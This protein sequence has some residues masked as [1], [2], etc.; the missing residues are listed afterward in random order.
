MKETKAPKGY[1]TD[2]QVYTAD[3]SGANRESSPVKLSVSDNPAN[4]PIAMLL[5]KYDGQKTYNGAGNLP[6]GSATLAGAEFTVDYYATLDYKSYDDLKK[7]DI[8]STRSWTFKT[9]ADGFSYFDTEHFVS[10]DAFFYNGQNNICIPRGTVVIRETKAPAGYVK[11]DDVSFQKI[12]ENPTT[13]AVRTYNVPKVAEQV[14]RSDIE[15]T[16]KADNGSAHLAGVPFKVT[17]H[18]R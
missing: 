6:Q 10:G 14:Y 4:D 1:F 9:D 18:H 13:D 16:K 11:S 15:F 2:S 12:Q 8:E 17:S 5:G 7:A 3:V